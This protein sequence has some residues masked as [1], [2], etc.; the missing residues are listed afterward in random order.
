MWYNSY[1]WTW[2]NETQ[3]GQAIFGWLKVF[4]TVVL[5]LFLADGAD[6]FGVTLGDLRAWLAAGFV[7]TL[8]VII[9]A[10]NPKDTRYGNGSTTR[11]S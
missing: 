6:L 3:T 10:L 4:V 1:M 5:G 9:N 8:P 11:L 7:A 2:L